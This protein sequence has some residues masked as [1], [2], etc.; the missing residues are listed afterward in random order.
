MIEQAVKIL[1]RLRGLECADLSELL[2]F[3]YVVSD[4]PHGVAQLFAND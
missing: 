2:L 4:I 1:T 3:V